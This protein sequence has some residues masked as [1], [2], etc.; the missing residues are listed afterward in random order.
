MLIRCMVI[1]NFCLGM[2]SVI[3]SDLSKNTVNL[4][5]FN[6]ID[7]LELRIFANIKSFV[8]F[9]EN[10]DILE[11][12]YYVTR[13]RARPHELICDFIPSWSYDI[14]VVFIMKID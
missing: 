3:Q 8:S 13:T 4:I 12:S 14:V 1:K 2:L 10:G 6:L 5:L 11:L 9:A 7:F